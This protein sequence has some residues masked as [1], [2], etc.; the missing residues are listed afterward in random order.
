M[1]WWWWMIWEV[2]EPGFEELSGALRDEARDNPWWFGLAAL[3]ALG[4]WKLV[5]LALWL[6]RIFWAPLLLA[7][8]VGAV[9]LAAR[10][11]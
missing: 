10:T 2:L 5:D 1:D 3:A 11:I 9:L 6:V 7:G 8:G 4:V